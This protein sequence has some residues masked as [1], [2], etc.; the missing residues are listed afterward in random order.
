MANLQGGL[1]ID[2]SQLNTVNVD[3]AARILTVGPGVVFADIYDPVYN[4]GF[5]IRECLNLI[6]LGIAGFEVSLLNFCR[7][8]DVCLRRYDRANPWR[9]YWTPY[10][11]LRLNYRCLGERHS[12][13]KSPNLVDS[14]NKI[15]S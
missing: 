5:Q 4:A 12:M 3:K 6:H 11:P 9:R 8:G 15:L 14:S 13:S 2:L 1:A 7:N 10:W